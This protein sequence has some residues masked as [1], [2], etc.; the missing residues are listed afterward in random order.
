MLRAPFTSAQIY[1]NNINNKMA[2]YRFTQDATIPGTA[3]RDG[4]MASLDLT[5]TFKKGEVVSGKV[6]VND[7]RANIDKANTAPQPNS[8]LV[9]DG[10][11]TWVIPLPPDNSPVEKIPF[12]TT[13]TIAASIIVGIAAIWLIKKYKVI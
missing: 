2:K 7:V 9:D 4:D 10:K 8:L 1:T 11:E 3:A 6:W 5:K 13:K 12:L